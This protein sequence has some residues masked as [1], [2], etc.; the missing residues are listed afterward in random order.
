MT[1]KA[2]TLLDT[3]VPPQKLRRHLLIVSI[4]TISLKAFCA[5]TTKLAAPPTPSLPVHLFNFFIKNGYKNA[6][7]ILGFIL[8]YLSLN[9]IF[10]LFSERLHLKATELN[11]ELKSQYQTI[12]SIYSLYNKQ[13]NP[14]YYLGSRVH[15]YELE[16]IPSLY[17]E[18]ARSDPYLQ[19]HEKLAN[20]I[21]Q[22]ATIIIK[23]NTLAVNVQKYL[24][25]TIPIII[26][27]YAIFVTAPYLLHIIQATW[28]F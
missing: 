2:L 12:N 24:T 21:D 11:E 9:Y 15:D 3:E 25:L 18:A 14:E 1:E 28:I 23:M 22:K 19:D 16:D 10:V 13:G 27:G 17:E 6:L 8:I 26:S 7:A 4:T 5:G 20:D